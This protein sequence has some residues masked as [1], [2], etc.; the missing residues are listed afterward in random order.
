MFPQNEVQLIEKK[1]DLAKKKWRSM[2]KQQ[3]INDGE[4]Y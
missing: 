2:G 3:M 4:F 1:Q